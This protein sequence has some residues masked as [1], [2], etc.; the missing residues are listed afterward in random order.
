MRSLNVLLATAFLALPAEA[1]MLSVKVVKDAPGRC[2]AAPTVAVPDGW[3]VTGQPHHNGENDWEVFYNIECDANPL[4]LGEVTFTVPGVTVQRA[5]V[6]KTDVP[7]QQTS[8]RVTFKLVDDRSRGQMMV[9]SYQ[10]PRGGRP[11]DLVHNWDMRRAWQYAEDPY[12]TGQVAAVFN[13]LLAAQEALRVWPAMQKPHA[14][15]GELYLMGH[16]VSAT[17]GHMDWPPHVHLMHY[18]FAPKEG[19]G[20][21]WV[22]RL[23]P[24]FY[25]SEH[26][27]IDR[28]SYAVIAGRGQSGQLGLNDVCHF[29]DTNGTFIVDLV[30]TERGLEMRRGDDLYTL[31]PD[32]DE[33]AATAVWAYHG[34][35]P[36]CRAAA[37]DD[38]AHGRFSYELKLFEGGRPAGTFRHG[39]TYDRFTGKLLQLDEP[40]TEA[41]Q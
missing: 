3:S 13:Y 18:Q 19:G 9:L 41:P 2:S 10:S 17:R 37:V 33:G 11:I 20:H 30:I 32:P 35:E 7:F 36:I 4:P 22:S 25:F 5:I 16:E 31:A 23:V 29:E 21:D 8:D 34:D 27:V 26:A 38:A 12:P 40:V 24:H 15:L 28:N 6:G 39:Y 1:V 14:W